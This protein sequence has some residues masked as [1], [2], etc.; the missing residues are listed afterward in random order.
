MIRTFVA[1]LI[2]V[3]C[4][5]VGHAQTHV[6]VIHDSLPLTV[7]V[8]KDTTVDTTKSTLSQPIA[9]L[10]S[11]LMDLDIPHV[12]RKVG[13]GVGFR[14]AIYDGGSNNSARIAA[15]QAA[16][17]AKIYFPELSA[18]AKFKGHWR[19]LMGDFRTMGEAQKYMREVRKYFPEAVIARREKIT[20]YE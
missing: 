17:K 13:K 20:L 14:I 4:S 9:F 12:P 3:V 19:C 2:M 11:L 15:H 16:S 18:D 5:I 1:F 8:V 10:D 7:P 6:P